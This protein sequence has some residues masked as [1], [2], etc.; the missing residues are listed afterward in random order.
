MV[1]L[2]VCSQC[3]CIG[4][5]SSPD[6]D[7]CSWEAGLIERPTNLSQHYGL[8]HSTHLSSWRNDRGAAPVAVQRQQSVVWVPP[9]AASPQT[10]AAAAAAAATALEQLRFAAETEAPTQH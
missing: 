3:A 9:P 7:S 10:S 8:T 4:G 6:P 1:A 2:A 5:R